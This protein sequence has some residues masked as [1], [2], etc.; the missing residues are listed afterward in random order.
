MGMKRSVQSPATYVIARASTVDGSDL[1]PALLRA[2]HDTLD[3]LDSVATLDEASTNARG[4][5]PGITLKIG[6]PLLA[7]AVSQ[8]SREM[9]VLDP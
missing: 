3:S 8:L 4:D 7:E 6:K 1:M 2:C 5:L 9:R